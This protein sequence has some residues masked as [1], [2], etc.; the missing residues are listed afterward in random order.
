MLAVTLSLAELK[1]PS[2]EFIV[3]PVPLPP[4]ESRKYSAEAM[5]DFPAVAS[6]TLAVRVISE[7]PSVGFG[8]TATLLATG[9]VVSVGVGTE[10]VNTVEEVV[11]QLLFPSFPWI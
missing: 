8:L 3:V 9:P 11:P 4:R 2:E 7:A 5:G 1:L 6:L 10:T